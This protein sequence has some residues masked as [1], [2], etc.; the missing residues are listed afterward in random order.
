MSDIDD[1]DDRRDVCC[2]RNCRSCGFGVNFVS[3]GAARPR[4]PNVS[5]SGNDFE[6]FSSGIDPLHIEHIA[7]QKEAKN[8]ILFN[9][10]E[11]NA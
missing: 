2:E 1:V 11:F 9:S 4:D 10:N 7:K 3:S 8:L 5:R 6:Y